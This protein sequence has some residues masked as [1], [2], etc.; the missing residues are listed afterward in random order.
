MEELLFEP[1]LW[2]GRSFREHR[3]LLASALLNEL[4]G[5]PGVTG[6]RVEVGPIGRE[7][8]M[9]AVVETDVGDLRTA[10]WSHARANIF[11]DASIHPANRKQLAPALA[12]REAA[13]RLRRRLAVPYALESRGLTITYEVEPGVER[14]WSAERSRFRGRTAVTR[15]DRI[16]NPGEVD[17]R[18][19]LAHFYEGPALRL[20]G[21]DG[22]AFLLPASADPAHGPLVSLC[23]ACQRW[24]EG[25]AAECTHCGKPVEVVSAT[26]ASR[27]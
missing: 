8:D 2:C 14:I 7:Y 21:Q 9:S 15:E 13:D 19:L 24:S 20:V 22:T 16:A 11:C 18:D 10:L 12:V 3:E 27:R 17:L 4:E 6:T 23:I 26:R 5:A 1:D 25:A